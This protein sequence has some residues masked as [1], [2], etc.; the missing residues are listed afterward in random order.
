MRALQRKLRA[1]GHQP[2]PVDGL[3][4]PLTEAAVERVQR[5]SGVSVDGIVGPQTRR[6]L[7]AEAPPLAPGAGHGQPGGS[8]QVRDVQRRLRALGQRP[9]PVD[10]R[11]GPRTQAAIERFQR[12]AGERPSGELSLATAAALARTDPDQPIRRASDQRGGNKPSQQA[13]RPASPAADS[14]ANDRASRAAAGD[15]RIE[16][17]DGSDLTAS[18]LLVVM[19]LAAGAVGVLIAYWLMATR[20]RPGPSGAA[21]HPLTPTPIPT[22]SR[23]AAKATAGQGNGVD[24]LGYVSAREPEAVDGPELRDQMAAI[25]TACS[26]RGLVLDEVITD[27]GQVT[28]TRA[29]ASWLAVRPSATRG[30]GGLMPG[31]S[32]TGA[33]EPLGPRG[34]PHRRL[35][36]AARHTPRSSRRRARHRY[37]DRGMK[38]GIEAKPTSGGSPPTGAVRAET[39]RLSPRDALISVGD[40]EQMRAGGMGP[41]G[42]GWE[43]TQISPAVK[44]SIDIV[45]AAVILL[46]SAPLLGLVAL[47]IVLESRGGVFYRA[48]RVGY[49]GK[50]LWM[51]KFRKMHRDAVGRPLTA[52]C[53]RRLTRVG[54][55]L[56][57]TRLDELPQFWHVLRGEM[58]IIGPRPEDPFF[59][60]CRPDDFAEILKVRPGIS[61]FSQLAF[62]EESRILSQDGSG[63]GLH[64]AHPSAE[65][66]AGPPV[67]LPSDA[68][69]G[70]ANRL[71]D[72]GCSAAAPTGGRS[73]RQGR[74]VGASETPGYLARL[75]GPGR[76][77]GDRGRH[78]RSR[79]AVIGATEIRM[80]VTR[81][82]SARPTLA[83]S[84]TPALRRAGRLRPRTR[85]TSRSACPAC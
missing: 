31:G 78:G 35:A 49:R 3:Y 75:G 64:S 34:R 69:S 2:G 28:D 15:S 24:A 18:V 38:Q 37:E 44:R 4:G 19:V 42:R 76:A 21:G 12:T 51:L 72:R 43:G 62:A 6:V 29:R 73:P 70:R 55:V 16:A 10:G 20:R 23:H 57:R 66:R 61:G 17:K 45:V 39:R 77:S 58:S 7:N 65:V 5:D 32:G 36:S 48:E 33:A 80:G 22:G 11:Y 74:H 13:Q 59:V 30:R 25:H 54:A 1:E 63:R 47:A 9:G 71:M 46:L 50:T 82:I 41:R 79:A 52:H 85:R 67:R 53:D 14:G 56:T 60:S 26:Q 81:S 8:P 27:V 68:G 40:A 83:S 84:L